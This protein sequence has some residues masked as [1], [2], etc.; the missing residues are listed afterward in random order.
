MCKKS[1]MQST[2]EEMK[3][4]ESRSSDDAREGSKKGKL[5]CGADTATDATKNVA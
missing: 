4:E 3:P 2:E 1:W 5:P